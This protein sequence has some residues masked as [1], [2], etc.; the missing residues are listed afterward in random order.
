MEIKEDNMKSKTG[1]NGWPVIGMTKTQTAE[2]I[3][4]FMQAYNEGMDRQ[5]LIPKAE[6]GT[7]PLPTKE[8]ISEWGNMEW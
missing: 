1:S 4:A 6:T 3:K 2:A 7:D 8:E 5:T